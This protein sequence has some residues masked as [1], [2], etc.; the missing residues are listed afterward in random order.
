MVE[1][2][3][4]ETA[5]EKQAREDY[6]IVRILGKDI[7]GNM[8]IYSGLARIKGISWALSNAVCLALKIDK[9]K[10]IGS[11]TDPEIK[12]IEEFL[13]D[14]KVPKYLLNRQGDFETGEDKHLTSTHLELRTEFDIKKLK[15]IKSY[16]GLRHA[17]GLPTRGQRTKS[18]F[19][20][21]R[22]KGAGIKKKK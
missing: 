11:L 13:K 12:K 18:N 4:Q 21:N 6:R 7:P 20:K 8:T 17:S 14:P 3:K 9:K 1:E 22:R 16:R 5:K 19:R 15:K 10:K 2:K